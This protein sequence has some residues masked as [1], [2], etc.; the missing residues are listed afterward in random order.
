MY[1]AGAAE[2]MES[3]EGLAFPIRLY[4]GSVERRG[5]SAGSGAEPQP[6]TILVHFGLKE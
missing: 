5:P 3:G 1:T 6:P 4:M 2:G